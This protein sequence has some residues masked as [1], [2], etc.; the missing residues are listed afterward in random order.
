[1]KVTALEEYGLRCMLVFARRGSRKPITLPEI[2]ATEGLSIPY[3]A[4]LLMI[5]KKAGL[6]KA[7][8][9]R[10]GG[11]IL[12]RSPQ[13]IVLKEI[14]EAL[15]DSFFG[16]HH[17]QR[18]SGDSEDC[19]HTEDCTVRDMWLTFDRYIGDILDKVT[20]ADLACGNVDF[21]GKARAESGS[22]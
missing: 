22:R 14:F 3:A 13:E 5:L 10:G 20:L 21:E 15:G 1:M 17:C 9:G 8:R 6:V 7:V 11:Y 19:V 16:S 4:K 2:G 12:A 18:Y